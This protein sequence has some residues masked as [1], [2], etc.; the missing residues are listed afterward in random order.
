MPG[1]KPKYCPTFTNEEIEQ[2][3]QISNKH[4]ASYNQVQRA[5]LALLLNEQPDLQNPVAAHIL[6]RHEHWVRYWRKRWHD[7]GFSLTDKPRIPTK[8]GFFPLKTTR[9]LKR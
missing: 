1:P 8:S 7:E 3:T 5:K 6:N 4:T 2:A 9:W